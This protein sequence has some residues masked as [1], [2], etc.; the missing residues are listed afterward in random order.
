MVAPVNGQGAGFEVGAVG[1]LFDVRPSIVRYSY[2]VS[3]D[4]QRF[5]VKRSGTRR[6]QLRPSAHL[7]EP[8]LIVLTTDY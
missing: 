2:D 8:A 6:L 1:P 3:P 5:L 4:G 7:S